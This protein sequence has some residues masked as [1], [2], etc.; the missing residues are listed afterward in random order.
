VGFSRA[1]Q[2]FLSA[3]LMLVALGAKAVQ[4]EDL[5]VANVE[6]ADHSA[7]QLAV[8]EREALSQVLIKV[9]G[10]SSVLA[11][12]RIREAI[13]Q[14]RSWMQRYQYLRDPAGSLRLEV[15]FDPNM[16]TSLITEAQQRLWT[17]NRPSLLVWLVVDD[18]AGRRYGSAETQPELIASLQRELFRRGV[19]GVFPLYDI[20]DAQAVS[21]HDLWQ[22]QDLSVYRGSR[23]YDVVNMLVGRLTALSDGRWMGD[24][25]YLSDG[26]RMATS[27]YGK[28]LAELSGGGI[29]FVADA[30]ATRYAVAAGAG[31][32]ASVLVRVDGV[33]NYA[34]YQTL[35]GYL[36][37]IEI[38]QST[39]AAYVEADSMVFRVRSRASAPQLQRIIELNRR[40]VR[41]DAAGLQPLNGPRAALVYQWKP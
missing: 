6:V 2:F 32:L 34:D 26:E 14:S 38:V 28:D 36:E 13:N 22:L 11:D 24:W 37:S 41:L 35:T 29:D 12:T 9:S 17:A 5:Y 21:I 25:V 15:H 40:L 1:K 19:P 7:R 39:H 3:L 27:V 20:E 8:A 31:E 30:M 33:K 18:S 16:I 23:R 10:S 4:V